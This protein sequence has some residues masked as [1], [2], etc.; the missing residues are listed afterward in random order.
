LPFIDLTNDPDPEVQARRLVKEQS[1][2]VYDLSTGPL[3]SSML[4]QLRSDEHWLVLPAH[5]IIYDGWS[6]GIYFREL[7]L[8]YES[9]L[10]EDAPPLPEIESLQY[11]DYAVWERKVLRPGGPAYQQAIAWWEKVLSGYARVLDLP[12]R[13]VQRRTGVDPAEGVIYWGLAPEISQRLTERARELGATYYMIRLAAFVALLAAECGEPDI[14]IGT[15]VTNRNRLALQ[16]MFG[17]F[18]NLVALRLRCSPGM[19]FRELLSAVRE[20]V[21]TSATHSAIPYEEVRE[22]L[23]Q[24]G[25]APPAIQILF[26]VSRHRSAVRLGDARLV[27]LPTQFSG[28]PRG[29]SMNLDQHNE[30]RNCRI[31]FDASI[32]EPSGVHALIDGYRRLLDAVSRQPDLPIATL[33]SMSTLRWRKVLPAHVVLRRAWRRLRRHSL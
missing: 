27:T 20:R 12:F 32:Y 17:F 25:V 5:H 11:A 14:V 2:R 28:M 3:L 8:L 19:S 16:N 13:R 21:A 24:R 29:F 7:A 31:T 6:W 4:V 23:T 1:R 10:R 18:V 9:G 15:Y 33:L 22:A 26:H 30:D